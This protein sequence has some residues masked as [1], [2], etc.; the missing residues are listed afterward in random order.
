MNILEIIKDI[1]AYFL[2]LISGIAFMILEIFIPGFW[3]ACFGIAAI[4]ASV[5]AGLGATATWQV[6]TFSA[7]LLVVLIVIRP[8]MLKLI[9]RNSELPTAVDALAGQTGLVMVTIDN[10]KHVGRVKV[11]GDNWKAVSEDNSIIRQGTQVV[12]DRVEGA[13][14]YVKPL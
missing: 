6:I 10:T 2:W 12:V 9:Y 8:L 7:V 5:A 1:P 14:I 3:I 4:G 13:S 11:K